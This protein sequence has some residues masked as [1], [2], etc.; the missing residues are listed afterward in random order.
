MA[1]GP[2]ASLKNSI[3]DAIFNNT[4]FAVAQPYVGIHSG[5]PGDGTA[6]VI[7]GGRKAL[8]S[9]AASAGEVASDDALAWTTMPAVVVRWVSL[10]TDATDGTHLWNVEL[11]NPV[12]VPEGETFTF[13]TGD[14]T[15]AVHAYTG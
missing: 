11:P 2:S 5:D 14:I 13:L 15:A 3:L 6:N 10:W 1:A 12:V 7:A 4:S 9:A 8:S